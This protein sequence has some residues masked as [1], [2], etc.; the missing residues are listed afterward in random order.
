MQICAQIANDC[1]RLV[2][3]LA[4]LMN[5]TLLAESS[6]SSI[7]LSLFNALWQFADISQVSVTPLSPI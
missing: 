7:L 5:V 2:C 4:Q 3:R 1:L 6:N